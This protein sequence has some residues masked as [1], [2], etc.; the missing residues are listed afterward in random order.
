MLGDNSLGMM[1]E[2]RMMITRMS[3]RMMPETGIMRHESCPL[4]MLDLRIMREP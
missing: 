2:S 3:R 1:L 4:M